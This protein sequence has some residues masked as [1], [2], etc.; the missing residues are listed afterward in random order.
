MNDSILWQV[1]ISEI[2]LISVSHFLFLF[3]IRTIFKKEQQKS[4]ENHS[5]YL[6]KT[7]LSKQREYRNFFQ[8]IRAMAEGG[9][10][11][12]IVDY[13]DEILAGDVTG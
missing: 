8:V 9:K 5:T 6:L 11:S 12:E 3:R 7:I 4:E 10:T 2:I 1:L 13:I